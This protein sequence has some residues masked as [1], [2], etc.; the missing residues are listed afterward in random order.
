MMF[1]WIYYRVYNIVTPD[2]N[3]VP[4]LTIKS[5]KSDIKRHVLVFLSS[6][7]SFLDGHLANK[8]SF[9]RF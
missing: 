1:L 6:N 2:F 5:A 3:I 7:R 4:E 9:E 8:I